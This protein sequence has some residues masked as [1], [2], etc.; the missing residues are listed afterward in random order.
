IITTDSAPGKQ[1]WYPP[2][3]VKWFSVRGLNVVIQINWF[4]FPWQVGPTCRGFTVPPH[5]ADRCGQHLFIAEGSIEWKGVLSG[6]E[7]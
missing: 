1:R 7:Y 4:I 5:D 3:W 6:R 2:S